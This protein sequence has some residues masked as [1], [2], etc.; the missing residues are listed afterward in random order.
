MTATAEPATLAHSWWQ[1]VVASVLAYLLFV[2]ALLIVGII[3]LIYRMW[4]AKWLNIEESS[5]SNWVSFLQYYFTTCVAILVPVHFLKR[6][7]AMIASVALGAPLVL[8]FLALAIMSMLGR[9]GSNDGFG[10]W[11]MLAST[12]GV[13]FGAGSVAY[14]GF[15]RRPGIMNTLRRRG[16]AV[17]VGA[18]FLAVV[19]AVVVIAA[20]LSV[21]PPERPALSAIDQKAADA[22][23][24]PFVDCVWQAAAFVDDGKHA[25]DDVAN[26][27]DMTCF[28]ERVV[29]IRY[30]SD[31]CIKAA[32]APAACRPQLDAMVHKKEVALVLQ[33]RA[34]IGVAALQARARGS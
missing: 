19:F 28:K 4:I 20:N 16:W 13:A 1:T 5:F 6:A 29:A 3:P 14:E 2:P 24:G 33:S 27:V 23:T 26:M 18:V 15:R 22:A 10:L 12:A 9:L 11:D 8:L 31:A 32:Y 7:D 34:K 30:L 25:V 21:E 17:A